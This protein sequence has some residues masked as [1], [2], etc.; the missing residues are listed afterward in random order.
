MTR[1]VA[2]GAV[3]GFAITVFFLAVCQPK[4]DSTPAPAPEGENQVHIVKELKPVSTERHVLPTVPKKEL[5]SV[6]APFPLELIPVRGDG[7]R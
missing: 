2:I 5:P 4:K 7:G 6:G 3:V 1:Q